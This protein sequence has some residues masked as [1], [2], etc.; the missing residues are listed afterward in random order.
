MLLGGGCSLIVDCRS[1]CVVWLFVV[2]WKMFL[3]LVV[4]C[5]LLVVCGLLLI[6]GCWLFFVGCSL[7]FVGCLLFVVRC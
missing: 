5:W 7:L 1:L 6:V 2:C 3:L 4:G